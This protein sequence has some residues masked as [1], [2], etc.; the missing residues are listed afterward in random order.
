MRLVTAGALSPD[1]WGLA[2]TKSRVRKEVG[3]GREVST[4]R[5]ESSFGGDQRL[6]PHRLL[7]ERAILRLPSY[8]PFAH[9]DFNSRKTNQASA[10]ST[11]PFLIKIASRGIRL[12]PRVASLK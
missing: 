4:A 7:G 6:S 9:D 8:K 10:D 5:A 11:E 1:P 2:L 12:V 3:N